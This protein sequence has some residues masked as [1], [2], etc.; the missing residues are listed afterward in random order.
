VGEKLAFVRRFAQE[1]RPARL[2]DLGCNTGEFSELA[3]AH[4]AGAVVGIDL[5]GHACDDAFARARARALD[6]TVLQV[7][8]ANPSPP[9]GWRGREQQSLQDRLRPDGLI[10]L[11]V[12]H[13]FVIGK[14]LPLA[15]VVD[16]LV[17]LA[18]HG[19]IEF[20]AKS[21]EQVAKMLKFREDIFPDYDKDS[22]L[23]ALGQRARI[24][25]V[26]DIKG[27]HRCLVRYAPAVSSN[28]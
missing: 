11:A 19:V 16:Y 24:V 12:I 1:V 4:G 7:D 15:D 14:N 8:M 18:P 3:L 5:D 26:H 20:V 10:A 28:H 9:Q 6:L 22:F 21:D 13:H 23:A 27:G 2:L 25:E 17:G